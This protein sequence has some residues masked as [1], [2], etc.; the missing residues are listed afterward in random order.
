[1][2]LSLCFSHYSVLKWFCYLGTNVENLCVLSLPSP[3]RS[4]IN[5]NLRLRWYSGNALFRT[6]DR[7]DVSFALLKRKVEKY[8]WLICCKRKGRIRNLALK[9]VV[10]GIRPF[11]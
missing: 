4:H 2:F 8:Y 6:S 11:F 7:L 1:V 5:Q 10:L 3:Y 9:K